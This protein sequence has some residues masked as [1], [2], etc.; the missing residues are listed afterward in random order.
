MS[1]G[2]RP[3]T[4]L[5]EVS[6][7]CS[8]KALRWQAIARATCLLRGGRIDR[9]LG[10]RTAVSS[11]ALMTR[12]WR[13]D[14]G[15]GRG[16]VV[17][18]GFLGAALLPRRSPLR[19]LALQGLWAGVDARRVGRWISRN[20]GVLGVYISGVICSWRIRNLR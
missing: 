2:W 16:A 5:R 11:S 6:V 13:A 14:K 10:R 18:R 9:W 8:V 4:S 15:V 12:G 20:L 7:A 19:G 3:G 1:W 17:L